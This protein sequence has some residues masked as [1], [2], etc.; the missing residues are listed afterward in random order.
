[1]T[2]FTD[3]ELLVQIPN[4]LT[5]LLIAWALRPK[6][7]TRRRTTVSLL[8]TIAVALVAR[9][10]VMQIATMPNDWQGWLRFVMVSVVVSCLSYTALWNGTGIAQ[11]V[12]LATSPDRTV[13]E[14]IAKG[15]LKREIEEKQSEVGE[16]AS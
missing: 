13:P 16:H 4:V 9:L 5:P 10:A 2:E 3:A 1:M 8:I 7:S 12:E 11:Q 6:W 15:E 14:I